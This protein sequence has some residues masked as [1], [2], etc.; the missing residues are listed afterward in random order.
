MTPD[1]GSTPPTS[2]YFKI[3][4]KVAE[5]NM[6][7]RALGAVAQV[8]WY[9][10]RFTYGFQR[11]NCPRDTNDISNRIGR[12]KSSVNEA[13]QSLHQARIIHATADELRMPKQHEI[14]ETEGPEGI[15]GD[16]TFEEA[17]DQ[18]AEVR[19]EY[20]SDADRNSVPD[21]T[22]ISVSD[23]NIGPKPENRSDQNRNSVRIDRNIG[24]STERARKDS[25]KDT[26][27]A[28]PSNGYIEPSGQPGPE[29]AFSSTE[30]AA[31]TAA[32]AAK[33]ED[34]DLARAI[35]NLPATEQEPNF[36][37]R[38]NDHRA[39][40]IYG[41]LAA[42]SWY[43]SDGPS[44][45]AP[46]PGPELWRE[47]AVFL[48]WA[49]SKVPTDV[50]P[51]PLRVEALGNRI[52]RMIWYVRAGRFDNS[53]FWHRQVQTIG[54][55]WAKRE[56]IH[57]KYLQSE[58]LDGESKANDDVLLQ[59]RLSAVDMRRAQEDVQRKAD[60]DAHLA[61]PENLLEFAKSLREPHWTSG[62]LEAE[63]DRYGPSG[64]FNHPEALKIINAQIKETRAFEEKLRKRRASMSKRIR[65]EAA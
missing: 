29:T 56:S 22:G 16:L 44:E 34:E 25:F 27:K 51:G 37:A 28:V 43:Q 61:N 17:C 38:R 24:R 40:S 36:G 19:P 41:I 46:I 26:T 3:M 33:R 14:G 59:S 11:L 47:A 31:T 62:G 35:A 30:Q 39:N 7:N 42:W 20:R 10:L 54:G 63:A 53:N 21:A 48:R 5:A 15:A 60:N 9:I 23:R 55:L 1:K 8:H 57:A 52:E 6:T 50:L 13:I 45:D 64:V 32:P 2:Q 12:S 18:A 58:F 49:D 65:A 4:N